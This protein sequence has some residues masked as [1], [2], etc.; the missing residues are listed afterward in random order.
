MKKNKF[1]G[2]ASATRSAQEGYLL[3]EVLISSALLLVA[4]LA[5]MPIY[6]M[7]TR[8][9]AYA[10]DMT[11]ASAL[12]QDKAE[13]F[14]RWQCDNI[15][16]GTCCNEGQS[17]SGACPAVQF[18]VEGITYTRT[19]Q[20]KQRLANGRW[21]N[22][23]DGAAFTMDYEGMAWMQVTVTPRRTSHFSKAKVKPA[24]VTYW[25]VCRVSDL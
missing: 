14:Q 18:K 9:N 4:L 5:I 17:V 24:I 7:A 1:V 21:G 19:C 25:R 12:A 3:L 20:V 15:R 13:D 10:K 22:D 11:I 2:S 8:Q 6:T 16:R 23:N